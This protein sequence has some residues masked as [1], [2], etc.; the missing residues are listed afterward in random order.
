[1]TELDEWKDFGADDEEEEEEGA[2]GIGT[3]DVEGEKAGELGEGGEAGFHKKP[4]ESEKKPNSKK[5]RAAAI[6]ARKRR[7]TKQRARRRRKG[8]IGNSSDEEDDVNEEAW[9]ESDPDD[10][11]GDEVKPCN[12]IV[13]AVQAGVDWHVIP[14]MELSLLLR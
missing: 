14:R 10:H 6:V 7:A 9:D 3:G 1:M 5:R 13:V 4:D 8:A 2:E 11:E 12:A